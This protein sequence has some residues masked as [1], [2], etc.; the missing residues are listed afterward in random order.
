MHSAPK[1]LVIVARIAPRQIGSF[2]RYL[3]AVVRALE[4][5]GWEVRSGFSG[6]I[7]ESVRSHFGLEPAGLIGDLGAGVAGPSR[8][9]WADLIRRERPGVVW[10]HFFGTMDR[11]A[12]SVR[13]SAPRA[14]VV[15]TDH[16]SRG[17][18][19]RGLAREVAH[20]TRRVLA[21]GWVDEY[22]AVSQFVADRLIT[23]DR[24]DPARVRVI[25][26]AVDLDDFRPASAPT[27]PGEGYLA[28]VCYLRP[29]KGVQ[30]LLRAMAILRHAGVAPRLLVVGDGP[31][32]D[33]YR[34]QARRDDLTNIEFLGHRNDV[35]DLLRGATVA[36]IPSVWPEA[37]SFVAAEAQAAAVP[38]I[39]SAIGGLTEVVADGAT[40]L[41][42]PP[43][44]P[45]ALAGALGR[46]AGDR[47][48]RAA[49][50]RAGRERA[51]RMF[52]LAAKVEETVEFL[53]ALQARGPRR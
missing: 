26:N 8:A 14:W 43:N 25:A 36:I 17:R 4:G 30:V 32:L 51:E 23:S 7:D 48:L 19:E 27:S 46:L 13:R 16:I 44:D 5:R 52:D 21:R 22:I 11:F 6:P 47:A 53:E 39:A 24:V 40:G 18:V 31:K 9:A 42:V 2:E 33:E 15:V 37:F 12:R 35:A 49:L 34:E 41:L 10:S 20:R 45:E 38:V 50:G 29:E 1:K 28:T 3:F